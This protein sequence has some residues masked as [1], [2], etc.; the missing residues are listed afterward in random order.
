MPRLWPLPSGCSV[1]TRG[2]VRKGPPSSGQLVMIGSRSSAKSLDTTCV[3]GPDGRSRVP[4]RASWATRSRSCQSVPS[5]GG[6]PRWARAASLR[7]TS[8]GRRPNARSTRPCVP[9]RF[10]TS[11]TSAPFTLVK[12]SAGPPA[13]ITRRWISATSRRA[14]TGTAIVARSPSRRS[15]SRYARRSG[16][17]G[18]A[19]LS[20]EADGRQP[21]PVV[22]RDL[23]PLVLLQDR[24]VEARRPARYGLE[25]RGDLLVGLARRGLGDH[26][27]V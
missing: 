10:V 11:G 9:N 12:R 24:H 23:V 15:W 8:S 21:I 2:R 7:T 18:R 25:D 27:H 4:S 26:V 13:A 1:Y 19:T 6:A 3:I 17:P 20:F 14:S 16:K 22:D 5:P